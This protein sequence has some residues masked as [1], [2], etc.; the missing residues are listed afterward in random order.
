MNKVYVKIRSTILIILLLTGLQG[1]KAQDQIP[2]ISQQT[3]FNERFSYTKFYTNENQQTKSVGRAVLYSLILPGMGE[4]YA[5]NLSTGK[6]FLGTEI[7]LWA[8]VYGLNAYGNWIRDDARAFAQ[9][10]AGVDWAGKDDQFLVN[11]ANFN[12]REEYNEK[13]MR[14][15]DINAIY[16][17]E[18]YAWQWESDEKRQEF[19][20]MRVRSDRMLNGV[21]F[22]G[23]AIVANHIVSAIIA[24]NSASRYNSRIEN[25]GASAHWS[26]GILPLQN[27]FV[28]GIQHTF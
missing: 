11:V 5:D 3:F 17:D 16:R 9:T 15:R 12:S 24:G 4:W 6:Y 25:A 10:H 20:D 26:F 23:A 22:V 19:R 8:S 2:N 18:T 28:A 14:D 13:K 7:A 21:K 27:G 1:L